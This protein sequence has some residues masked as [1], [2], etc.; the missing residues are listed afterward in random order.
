MPAKISNADFLNRKS[1]HTWKKRRLV[2]YNLSVYNSLDLASPITEANLVRW[3]RHCWRSKYKLISSV[4][5]TSSHGHTCV[6]WAAKTDIHQFC[7]DT[8]CHLDDSS[9][10]MAD[11]DGWQERFKGI[12]AVILPWWWRIDI[13]NGHWL[14]Y[15][16]VEIICS[17]LQ[18]LIY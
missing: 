18:V 16:D 11:S 10:A 17:Y 15:Y 6:G 12:H 7:A 3:P 8:G 1:F 2:S 9:I 4:L 13:N 14:P 5:W